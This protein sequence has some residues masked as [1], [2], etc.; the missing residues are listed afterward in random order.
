MRFLMTALGSY[1]DVLPIVGLAAALQQRGHE[2][3]VIANP[4]FRPVVESAGVG[5]LP[6]GSEQEYDDLARHPDLWNT[7]RGPLLVMRVGMGGYLR[8]LYEVIDANFSPGTVLVA[9]TLDVASRVHQDRYGTA[10]A[11]LHLAPVALRSFYQSPQYFNMLMQDW[12]PPWLRRAQFWLGDIMIDRIVAPELDSLRASLGL[13]PE[14]GIMRDWYFSPHLVLGLF[15][16]WF[17]PP[18]PDW[19]Q[20][21]VLTGFPLW[22]Q[23]STIALS[24]EVEDFL[25]AGESPIVFAPGSAMTQG[26]WFF[27][28]AIDACQRLGQ[29]GILATK[30]PEQL[31]RK[32]PAGVLHCD[33]VPFSQLLPRAAALVQHGGIGTCA[34]GLAAGLPQLVMPMAFDQL[35]NAARLTRLGVAQKIARKKFCGPA[36][37]KALDL[38]LNTES[39]EEAATQCARQ[40]DPVAALA[41]SC[42]A[43]ERLG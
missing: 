7:F 3:S 38:L 4:H 14:R 1:G 9:H 8:R 35:D 23:S 17:A 34:Q 26:E 15:P 18:Q 20:N 5:Y 10:V 40:C 27:A 36:V 31:P 29:R 33:F 43:L 28:A 13:K 19:P 2:V 41:A 12:V 24:V 42:A 37:A 16:D 11:S 30:Y 22:D 21:T 25:R 32:L 39:V 6:L